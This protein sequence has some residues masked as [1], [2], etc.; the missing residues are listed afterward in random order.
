[1]SLL[2]NAWSQ[3]EEDIY[4]SLFGGLGDGIYVLSP[5]L[6]Q[7]QF[8]CESVD[9]RWLNQG[10]FKSRPSNIRST[11]SYVTS[12]MSNPWEATEAEEYSGLGMELVLE[13]KQDEAWAIPLLQSLLAFNIL[14]SVGKYGDRP[15]LGRGDRIPQ[16][17]EPNIGGLIL[18]EPSHFPAEFHL[19]S[20]KVE[21]V[22]VIGVTSQELQYAK[23]HGSSELCEKLQVENV[24]PITDNQRSSI[25][26]E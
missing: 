9:P 7:N 6:F 18:W 3:R 14:L 25:P 19:A 20:G 26:L 21:L 11:W 12:G 1:M 8:G 13:T 24:F 16:T 23:E 5:Q 17:V 15:I 4:P 2:E 22:Q 10:V